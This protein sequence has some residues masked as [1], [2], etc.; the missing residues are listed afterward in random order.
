MNPKSLTLNQLYGA[1]DPNTLEWVDGIVSNILRQSSKDS[2]VGMLF[3]QYTHDKYKDII[4]KESK[5]ANSIKLEALKEL[6]HFHNYWITYD[7][8]VD[9]LWIESQ[10]SVLDDSKVLTLVNG[11][12][13][14]FPN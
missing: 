1:V 2:Q 4:G 7:G 5:E 3:G 9:T 10:N 6:T 11:E 13:I 12:R 14:A 8:P